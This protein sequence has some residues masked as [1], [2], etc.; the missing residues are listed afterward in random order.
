MVTPS[1]TVFGWGH[2]AARIF[3]GLLGLGAIAWGGLVLPLFCRQ[4]APSHV[5]SE[6]LQG[7]TFKI[8]SLLSE[9]QRAEAAERSSFC[10]PTILHDAVILRLAILNDAIAGGNKALEDVA[11]GRQYEATRAAL[12][13]APADSFA[14]LT[15]FWLDLS[16][17]GL[18]RDD[19]TYLRLSYASG[20]NEGWIALRRSRLAIPLLVWL[21]ADLAEDAT[22]EFIN[23][24]NTGMLYP[25]TAQIFA[26]APPAAQGRLLARL[27]FAQAV[28]RQIF[29]R[30]LY[31]QG[32]D[33]NIPGVD[34]K[35][36]PW[37]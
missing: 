4:I 22:D 36:H 5:A 13:C 6:L 32:F 37:Q 35:A 14:W 10:D 30:T 16:K 8:Q 18:T 17:H 7:H 11:Y 12:V 1:E 27:K 29:A 34:V 20:P 19:E 15:L 21:P 31:D 3:V 25:E 28:P 9:A 2:F 26:S 24:V 33:I 23:L